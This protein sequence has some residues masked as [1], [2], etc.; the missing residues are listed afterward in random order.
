[1]WQGP[2]IAV[3]RDDIE[4]MADGGI[5]ER[6]GGDASFKEGVD[7]E[8]L[9]VPVDEEAGL[10]AEVSEGFGVGDLFVDFEVA[11]EVMGVFQA[12]VL[13]YLQPFLLICSGE[14]TGLRVI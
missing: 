6:E 7:D 4:E 1:M 11:G 2:A 9:G 8:I 10:T 13:Q 12:A 14:N 5:G 3:R